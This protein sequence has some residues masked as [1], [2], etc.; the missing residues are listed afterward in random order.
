MRR[1]ALLLASNVA[2]CSGPARMAALNL[3]RMF[4]ARPDARRTGVSL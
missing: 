4:T 3:T 2:R 1:R